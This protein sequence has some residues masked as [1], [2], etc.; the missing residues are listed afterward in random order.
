MQDYISVLLYP[1]WSSVVLKEK[2]RPIKLNKIPLEKTVSRTSIIADQSWTRMSQPTQC[3][4]IFIAGKKEATETTWL[5]AMGTCLIQTWCHKAYDICLNMVWS[6][7]SLWLARV[8]LLWLAETL[9]LSYKDVPLDQ[10]VI[11]LHMILGY[12]LSCKETALD[13]TY[14]LNMETDLS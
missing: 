7:G 11:H 13:Q 12:H 9:L 14:H 4:I 2:L 10:I 1:T 8:W 3:T 5:A 6:Y